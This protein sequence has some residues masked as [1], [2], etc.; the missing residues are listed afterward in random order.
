MHFYLHFFNLYPAIQKVC[1]SIRFRTVIDIVAKA[2]DHALIKKAH[3]GSYISNIFP[4]CGYHDG[5]GK[6][7]AS[8]H[9]GINRLPLG[10][11]SGPDHNVTTGPLHLRNHILYI[12][13]IMLTIAVQLENVI[14][15]IIVRI[16]HT[17]FDRAGKS[18][19]YR[20]IHEIITAAGT[21][22]TGVI[23]GAII[24]HHV[25]ILRI[26]P[27]Q[28]VYY[29]FYASSFIVSWYNDQNF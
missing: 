23:G 3:S 2:F 7:L 12:L 8:N 4:A 14:I 21:Y 13:W 28:I 5:V 6:Q 11:K 18:G 24:D 27:F 22:L 17:A 19:V 26:I 10:F 20:K 15:S 29:L 25:I 9:S 1:Q 16:A